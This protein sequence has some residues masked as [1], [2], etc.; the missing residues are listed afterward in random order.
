MIK[1][2]ALT[3]LNK[4]LTKSKKSLIGAQNRKAPEQDIVNLNIKIEYYEYLISVVE[5]YG[6]I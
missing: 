3:R 4:E 1:E 2:Q 5:N 6:N